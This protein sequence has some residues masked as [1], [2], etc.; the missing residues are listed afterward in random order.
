VAALFLDTDVAENEPRHRT[1]TDQ[2]YAGDQSHRLRQEAVLGIGGVRMLAALGL[3]DVA[4]FHMNEGHSALLTLALLEASSRPDDPAQVAAVRERCVFTTHTPVPEGHDQFN[5][6][7][8]RA[9]LGERT[10]TELEAL[11]L[12]GDEDELNMTVLGMSFS[13]SINAVSL[14]HGEVSRAMFPGFS[15]SS[16]TNGVHAERWVSPSFAEL[17]DRYIPSWRLD[18]TS[19]HEAVALPLAAVETAHRRAKQ[20][21]IELVARGGTALDP[22]ALTLGIARRAAAY[23]RLDLL[24][25]RPEALKEIVRSSGPLQIV[26]SGKAHP[27]DEK[28]KRMIAHIYEAAARV[29]DVVSVVYVEDYS[30]DIAAVICA[31]SDVWVNTPIWGHEASGTS[32][33]KAALNGV[34][35]LSVLDG[36]WPEGHVEGV[37]GWAVGNGTDQGADADAASLYAVLGEVVAPL[38]YGSP[39]EFLAVRRS[40]VALNGSSFTAERMARQ[41]VTRAYRAGG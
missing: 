4:T 11:R 15:I 25:S 24:L 12:F 16:I 35:S 33:M 28:G 6:P 37:T 9:V 7:L 2:I 19:L 13:R 32:G 20:A 29:A 17:F 10:E 8:V 38:F 26:Y 31:G 41:Y 36:W 40:T 22:D 34:P 23:K 27:E 39:D 5:R 21:L 18:N 1:I 14:L 3:P 30:L